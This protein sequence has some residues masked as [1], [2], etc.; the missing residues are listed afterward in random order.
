MLDLTATITVQV[1]LLGC[2]Q[3]TV[4]VLLVDIIIII[5]IT[6][7]ISTTTPTVPTKVL[8]QVIIIIINVTIP[9][10]YIHE[11]EWIVGIHHRIQTLTTILVADHRMVVLV[12]AA[13]VAGHLKL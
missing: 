2:I 13:M 4:V 7:H 5:L 9:T 11:T 10:R 12:V 3:R 8:R 1:E 6:P